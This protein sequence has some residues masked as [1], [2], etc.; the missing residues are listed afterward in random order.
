FDNE[1]A[2]AGYT[3]FNVNASYTVISGRKAHI[4]SVYAYNLNDK[5][6]RNH[7]SFL[8]EIAPEIGRGARFNYA[9]RF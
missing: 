4:F 5:L 7:L 9:L 6:Y 1:T 8:K 3:V 2:T